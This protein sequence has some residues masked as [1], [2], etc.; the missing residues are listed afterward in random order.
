[1]WSCRGLFAV[2]LKLPY[3]HNAVRPTQ[4]TA[5]FLRNS[6]DSLL[7]VTFATTKS[8]AN[9]TPS[10]LRGAS[11]SITTPRTQTTMGS[12]R[13]LQEDW[14]MLTGKLSSV[15]QNLLQEGIIWNCTNMG[16]IYYILRR[17]TFIGGNFP[18]FR[19][20]KTGKILK[21]PI[22]PWQFSDPI[23]GWLGF[24]QR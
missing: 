6:H 23:L 3:C 12:R 18:P 21:F 22:F 1:M 8:F 13:N 17:K 10:K 19:V 24:F 11:L 15:S 16:G 20:G 9:S 7:S 4:W 5:P 14:I 2:F